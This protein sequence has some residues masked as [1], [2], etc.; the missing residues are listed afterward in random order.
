M[1]NTIKSGLAIL[2]VITSLSTANGQEKPQMPAALTSL[3]QLEGNWEGPATL[4]MAGKTFQLSYHA[5]FRKTADGNGMTMDEGFSD[6][7]LGTLMGAN[8]IGYNANDGKIHWFSVDNFGTTH[9]H[10]GVWK[11]PEHFYMQTSELQQKK[12]YMEKINVILKDKDHLD[13]SIMATLDGKPTES[14]TASF[15][16]KS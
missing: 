6:P 4:N 11:T 9:D 15:T 12:R 10:L 5:N 7:E 14:V 1:K 13:L 8:L 3:L 2:A 16:R